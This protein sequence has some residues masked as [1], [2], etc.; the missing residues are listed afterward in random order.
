[1]MTPTQIK[2]CGITNSRDA[3]ACV[4]LGAQMIGLNFYRQSPRYIEPKAARQIVE[5]LPRHTDAVGIFV[6]GNADEIRNTANAAGVR[7][8][9]L[10][11]DFSPDVG[12]ELT[13]EFRVIQVFSTHSQF[14]PEEVL[15]FQDCDVLVDAHH[16]DLR[17]GTGQ[18]CDWSAARALL[19]FSRFLIL[20][21]GLNAENVASA[22]KAVTPNAV[23]VCSGVESAPGVKDHDAIKDFIAAVRTTE[24]ALAMSTYKPPHNVIL[25]EEKNL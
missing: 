11:G 9:Q 4:E 19:P 17:G 21:G 3:K 24:R 23:D 15:L 8:V 13:R 10:H 1:M 22:I 5:M 12:R 18:T 6:N 20:S 14:R 7:C 16:P 2:I 25:S